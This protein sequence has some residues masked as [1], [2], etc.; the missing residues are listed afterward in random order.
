MSDKDYGL[1]RKGF[2]RKQY[3]DLIAD[4]ELKARELYGENI[5][6]SERSFLG[7]FIRLFSWFLAIV[8][9]LAER[10][11]NA[12]SPDTAEGVNLDKTSKFI[13]TTRQRAVPAKYEANIEADPNTHIQR[14]FTV[15]TEG[16]I[17]FQTTSYVV[18]DSEGVA[19]VEIEAVEAGSIGNVG[20]TSINQITNPSPGIYSVEVIRQTILGRDEESDEAFR[21]RNEI[22][23]TR[24]GASSVD[25][26]RSNL[27]DLSGVAD[28]FVFEND[29]MVEV[30][31][32][33][34]KSIA[35]FV[36]GGEDEAVARN[37]LENK[38]G[39]IQSY[40]TTV[41]EVVD[42]KA[43]I[44]SIGFTRPTETDVYVDVVLTTNDRFPG[45]GVERVQDSIVRYIG[46]VDREGKRQAGL[47]IGH[48]VSYTRLIAAV[49]ETNG[50]DD[51]DIKL[52]LSPGDVSV[53][54]NIEV[55]SNSIASTSINKVVV[56]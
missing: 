10:V 33:P 17:L 43:R 38:S 26:V 6:L 24:G 5:N 49:Y 48:N 23:A 11:Y 36:Y 46:G 14:G 50:I 30:D 2:K 9:Q 8:W 45:D 22:S 41:V 44:H 28:A 15:Q 3:A 39:G 27:L 51:V 29:E 47:G 25:A 56:T 13:G 53:R 34:P 19:T 7:L 31:G 4:M 20:L 35:P 32:L 12:M 18:A 21:K 52:G 16:D 37:I 54:G 55:D 42:S 40:G 1:T